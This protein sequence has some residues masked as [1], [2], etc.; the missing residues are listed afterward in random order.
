MSNVQGPQ[1]KYSTL[2]ANPPSAAALA[3]TPD[4]IGCKWIDREAVYH[5]PNANPGDILWEQGALPI[6]TRGTSAH[7]RIGAKITAK[8]LQVRLI[9]TAKQAKNDTNVQYDIAERA[10]RFTIWVDHQP[11]DQVDDL[12]RRWKYNPTD[13]WESVQP[14]NNISIDGTQSMVNL[15][16]AGKWNIIWDQTVRFSPNCVKGPNAG[17]YAPLEQW[18]VRQ[19]KCYEAEI[20]LNNMTMMWAGEEIGGYTPPAR[21]SLV[22]SLFRERTWDAP[23]PFECRV[24][25]RLIYEDG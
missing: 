24:I 7:E 25:T 5:I 10:V 4:M 12:G 1:L 9:V 2:R 14:N 23:L 22:L 6:P 19:E 21:N 16:K 15:K 13:F 11:V 17:P 3:H 20:D 18:W 8:K